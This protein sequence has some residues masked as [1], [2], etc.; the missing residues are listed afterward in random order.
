MF[1]VRCSVSPR[2]LRVFVYCKLQFV[3]TGQKLSF[4]E[5]IC[6]AIFNFEFLCTIWLWQHFV[7]PCILVRLRWTVRIFRY[8]EIH[9]ILV[10]TEWDLFWIPIKKCIIIIQT[11]Q[12][13][14]IIWI[15]A[16]AFSAPSEDII[17]E[18]NDVVFT[19]FG[20]LPYDT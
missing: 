3:Q 4:C 14:Q 13:Y 5:G 12:M 1:L 7:C 15:R 8:F 19:V 20:V 17:P 16:D 10:V 18:G 2:T 6:D 11:T 9:V